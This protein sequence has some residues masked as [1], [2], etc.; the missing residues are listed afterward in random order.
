MRAGEAKLFTQ[1][2]NEQGARLNRDLRRLAVHR[3][4]NGDGHSSIPPGPLH[5]PP[6]R[7]STI[8]EY[9]TSAEAPPAD[10]LDC[11]AFGTARRQGQ[12][13]RRPLPSTPLA[14]V[15]FSLAPDRKSVGS[16]K[17]VSVRVDLG[18]RRI[19]KTKK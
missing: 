5:G 6:V 19:I 2:L 4:G 12:G 7:Y 15:R 10:R 11:R 14:A 13:R 8:R 18:G 9:G 17:S 3:H 16:G 1:K